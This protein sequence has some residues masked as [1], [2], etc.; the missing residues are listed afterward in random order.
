M[1]LGQ[2]INSL[3]QVYRAEHVGAM[4]GF[5]RHFSWMF[6][7]ILQRFPVELNISNS[8]ILVYHH[9]GV[10]ALVNCMGTYDYN[11]INFIKLL[12]KKL[13]QSGVFFDVGSNI[14]SYTLVASEV[15]T[16]NVFAFEPGRTAFSALKKNIEL[17]NRSNV[18]L[19]NFA[20]SDQES[21]LM[22]TNGQEISTNKVVNQPKISHKI[23]HVKSKTL[24]QV[25]REYDVQPNIVKIDVEGHDLKVL[26][27]FREFIKDTDVLLIE[28][29]ED[30]KI[31]KWL[32]SFGFEGPF[33]FHLNK[34]AILSTAQKRP[35]DPIFFRSSFFE[36]YNKQ[37]GM[38]KYQC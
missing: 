14:G 35:E 30:Y 15:A 22:L 2:L 3:N 10:A 36:E 6:R 1:G 5:L 29:G 12:L 18:K 32:V 4:T 17:N 26:K 11:N 7:R 25:C 33:Y 23:V 13:G 34:S 37:G 38:I 16:A 20:V 31:S 27:G 9:S 28:E 8:K 19:L 21:V 24:D